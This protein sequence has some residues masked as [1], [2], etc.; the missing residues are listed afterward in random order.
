MPALPDNLTYFTV[1]RTIY[2]AS[3]L[4]ADVRFDALVTREVLPADLDD[5]VVEILLEPIFGRIDSGVLVNLD[6]DT[7]VRLISA[8]EVEIL[9][10]LQYQ[11]S[12]FNASAELPRLVFAALDADETFDLKDA[13]PIV[14]GNGIPTAQGG[15]GF[16]F[17][18]LTDVEDEPAQ[19]QPMVGSGSGPVPVGAPIDFTDAIHDGIV[20]ELEDDETVADA[21]AAAV[22]TAIQGKIGSGL[23]YKGKWNASTNSPT[24]V[25]GTGTAGDQWIVAVTGTRNLGSGSQAFS[26]GDAAVYNGT[27]WQQFDKALLAVSGQFVQIGD[28]ADYPRSDSAIIEVFAATV[29]PNNALDGDMWAD[30]SGTEPV[31]TTTTLG[32][33][34]VGVETDQIL[35]VT[36]SVPTTGSMSWTRVAG[37]LPAGLVL[38]SSG[39]LSGTPTATGAYD[40][41]VKA[42][43][44]YGNDTQQYTG[45][46]GAAVAPTITTTSLGGTLQTGVSY[47][48]PTEVTGSAPITWAVYAGTLPDGLVLTSIGVISGTPTGSGAFDF[49]LRATNS[50]GYDDQQFTGTIAGTAPTISTTSL[51]PLSQGAAFLQ[52]PSFAGT[53]PITW[54]INAGTLPAGL[55]QDSSTGQIYGTPSGTGAYDFTVRAT[56]SYGHADQQYTGTVAAGAPVITTT[57]MG[58]IY[59]AVAMTKTL[60]VSGATPITW[61]KPAGTIPTGLSLDT[62]TGVI[63]GTASATGAYDF[64]IRATN[65]YDHDDQQYTGSVLES[66]PSITETSMNAMRATTSFTQTLHATGAPTIAWAVHAGTLPT[67]LSLDTSTGAISGT[68]TTAG[69]YDFTI[70]ASNSYGDDDQQFT[71]TV[72]SPVVSFDSTAN[73]S[74]ATSPLSVSTNAAAGTT[75]VLI[76]GAV[77]TS[78]TVTF[79]AA[80]DPTGANTAMTQ[81]GSSVDQGPFNTSFYTH[82]AVF[83]LP[84]LVGGAK[85]ISI[86]ASGSITT[87]YAVFVSADG[88]ATVGSLQSATGNST[89][90][91]QTVTSATDHLI[92]QGFYKA[93]GTAVASYNQ[94]QRG[95]LGTKFIVGTAAGASSVSFTAASSS[96][97]SQVYCGVA[98]DLSP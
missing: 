88:V 79:T 90:M 24:L 9:G 63:S 74:S 93:L 97:S 76:I 67:G 59:R 83:K 6:G 91:A 20:S 31:I 85:S 26:A 8:A 12:F 14:R 47:F 1:I 50:A 19:K 15:Q 57:I 16:S 5:G 58:T 89:S 36:G 70:R 3:S 61:S 13:A 30:Y 60:V 87:M 29:E 23:K 27:I 95:Y 2:S 45:T 28:D 92:V 40:F 62:S 64:T 84:S 39:E 68:P 75:G 22:D 11:A 72:A 56:N 73:N 48:Q 98:V 66:T 54:S 35:A 10:G 82:T 86:T 94:T 78:T 96:G 38:S 41:T 42:E 51:N 80:Y 18:G 7:G 37:T 43:N 17:A 4:I 77:N 49:T 34:H 53:S 71:G 44:G 32:T 81:V 52:I 21:A 65:S 25:D 33:L 55:S 46:V 69:A